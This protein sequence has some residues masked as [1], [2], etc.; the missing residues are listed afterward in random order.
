MMLK[1]INSKNA[2]NASFN[3]FFPDRETTLQKPEEG[4]G[5]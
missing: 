5:K 4:R 2:E 3:R 1:R